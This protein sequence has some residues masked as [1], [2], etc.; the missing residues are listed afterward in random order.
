MKRAR[1]TALMLN[2]ITTALLSKLTP[3]RLNAQATLCIRISMDPLGKEKTL[4]LLW[5]S[6]VAPTSEAQVVTRSTEFGNS[7]G[8][9]SQG[10][11]PFRE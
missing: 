2:V 6:V 10:T 7:Q 3:S 1:L 5:S 11:E 9:S 8:G 4:N